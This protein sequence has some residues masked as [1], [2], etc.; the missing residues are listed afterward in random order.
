M[1]QQSLRQSE[2][3]PSVQEEI[4]RTVLR[5]PHRKVDETLQLHMEQLNRD[6][7]LYGK[8]AAYAVDR[9][10]CSVRDIQ[11]VFISVLFASPYPEHREAAWAMYQDL[12]PF[13]AA[14]VIKYI[15]GYNE[16]VRLRTGDKPIEDGQ[17]GIS[18]KKATYSDS[19]PDKDLR[20]K[21]IPTKK[22]KIGKKLRSRIKKTVASEIE[23]QT[24]NVSHKC[25][26]KSLN[27]YAISAVKNYLRWREKNG[28][29]SLMEGALLRARNSVKY[30]YAKTH[31]LPGGDEKN[32][33]NRF[34]F[35]GEIPK[36]TR[37]ETMKK[38][39]DSTDPTEQAKLIIDGKLPFPVVCSLVDNI[40]P[41]LLVALV[42][43]MSPQEL[44]QNINM[45]KKNGA[46]DNADLRELIENKIKKVAKAGKGKVDALKAETVL[47]SVSGLS[48]ET[49]KLVTEVTD[50][51][52]KQHGNIRASTAL[53]VDKSG[54]LHVAIDLGKQIAAIVAQSV[55]DTSKFCCYVFDTT[56]RKIEC[57]DP[58]KKSS[59]DKSFAMVKAIGGT[60]PAACLDAMIRSNAIAEQI[61]IV[62]DEEE[63]NLGQFATKLKEY[64][65]QF[66]ITPKVIIVRCGSASTGMTLS[67]K[68]EGFDVDVFDCSK[69]DKVALP[70][71]ITLLSG[72]SVFDT[73]Q[74]IL[75]IP[76]PT[77]DGYLKRQ[78]N[79]PSVDVKVNK[80][81]S[82]V[83]V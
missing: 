65:K 80:G 54:S 34:L 3:L 43:T 12:P 59:W 14:R 11:D 16:V 10:N 19:F 6:P 83:S 69:T 64:S 63:N 31:L 20:G 68:K 26:G 76:L 41:T 61:I 4:F 51:Q 72:K 23:I 22:I 79:L 53:L 32:W 40:T 71:L 13:R 25:L 52:L 47:S 55:L 74:E 35:H 78:E 42:E 5:T 77:R 27:R 15:T 21:V 37:L 66:S 70:N 39:A 81:K 82:K 56:A 44:L 18:V 48:E 2:S 30:L 58:S 50:Q 62:T 9:G 67:L 75:E 1:N 73:I 33:V 60:A 36:G 17:F 38:I 8:L 28:N 46:F 49:R 57:D 24:L 7:Y 29:E 45:L